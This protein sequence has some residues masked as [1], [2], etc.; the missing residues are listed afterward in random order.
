MCITMAAMG[1][2]SAVGSLAIGATQ[3]VMS[4]QAAQ[5]QYQQQQM[6]WQMDNMQLQAQN[7]IDNLRYQQEVAQHNE[8]LANTYMAA[9][10]TY[11]SIQAKSLSEQ[12]ATQETKSVAAKEAMQAASRART[13]A[14]EAGVHGLSVDALLADVYR[15]QGDY[16][17]SLDA[18]LNTSRNAAWND[19]RS[20]QAQI[21]SQ[22]NSFIEPI[23]PIPGI[24]RAQPTKPSSLSTGLGIA[25]SALNSLSIYNDYKVKAASMA[26]SNITSKR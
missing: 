7:R 14:G 22:I 17:S 8:G 2:I 15:Q 24:M 26:P 18:N 6:Q 23:Q 3:A 13:A 20:A 4:G 21:T 9:S 11:A 19:A 25:S 5:Q 10:D 12:S 1:I 16:S